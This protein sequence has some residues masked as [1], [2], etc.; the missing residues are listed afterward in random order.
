M[1]E[2]GSKGAR[3]LPTTGKILS[4]TMTNAVQV[5]VLPAI[6]VTVRVTGFGLELIYE[7][8]SRRGIKSSRY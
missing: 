7:I 6:S 1:I 2:T 8:S 4:I 5:L 3:I